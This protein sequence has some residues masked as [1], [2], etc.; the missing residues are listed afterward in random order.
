VA[1]PPRP[2][3]PQLHKPEELDAAFVKRGITPEWET[4]FKEVPPKE[5]RDY[6]NDKLERRRKRRELIAKMTSETLTKLSAAAGVG[7]L[8]AFVE[9]LKRW[10]GK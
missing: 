7:A 1:R 10:I 2:V 6:L 3:D 8:W 9:Y 5:A 4:L